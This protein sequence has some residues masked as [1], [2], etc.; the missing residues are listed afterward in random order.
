MFTDFD[1]FGFVPAVDD[2]DVATLAPV[3]QPLLPTVFL[4]G[5]LCDAALWRPQIDALAPLVAP[6]VADLTLDDSIPA[7]AR[8]VLAAAPPRFAL[9]ALSMGGYVALEILRQAPERVTS[10]ALLD[11]S[12]RA[13]SAERAE[14]RRVG[15]ASLERGRFVGITRQLLE[16]LVG[17]DKTDGP[18]A[19]AL[20][21]MALRVGGA[22][23][24][25][26]QHAILD[27]ADLRHIL[28]GVRV[29][30]L[31]AVGDGDRITPPRD[32]EE[33]AALIPGA[34]L[35]VFE[36]CGHLPALELPEQTT[37]LLKWWLARDRAA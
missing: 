32:A 33:I 24:L 28:P 11:T 34:H 27:R 26:Q 37:A 20:R 5:L 1:A 12:A 29:Q 35:H 9:V 18:V 4:P 8:R 30:V 3:P 2:Q 25:R 36:N 15:M 7:M 19:E 17:A 31:V 14:Q 13:D 23:F 21:A 16:R 22:A 10:V 6:M